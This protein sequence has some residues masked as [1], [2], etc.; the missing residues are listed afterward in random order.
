MN[1]FT[2]GFY[3]LAARINKVSGTQEELENEQGIVS[4]KLPELDLAMPDDDL[5]KLTGE[6][7]RKWNESDV[8][9]EW[10]K[11]GEENERYWKGDQFTRPDVGKNRPLIDNA[12]FEAVETY[13]PQIKRQ[14]PEPVVT[15]KGDP[16]KTTPDQDAFIRDLQTELAEIADE[17]KMRLKL[18]A[19]TRHWITY[20]V[21]VEKVGWDLNRDIPT[22]KTIRPQKIILD[23]DAATDEDGYTGEY[24]GEYRKVAAGRLIKIIGDG[25]KSAM[26]VKL[27]K[28]L[29]KDDLGTKIQFIEWWTPQYMCWT[30]KDKVLLKKKN[31]HWNYDKTIPP[32]PVAPQIEGQPPVAP[33]QAQ[34]IK[35]VNHF[36]APKIPYIL[37]SVYNLGEKPVDDTS[38]IGQNLSNQDTINKR[39]RQIDRNADN[40]N[41]GLVISLERSGLTTSQA[42]GVSDA[43]RKGGVVAIPTG[44]PSDAIYRPQLPALPAEVFADLNDHRN[45]LGQIFGTQG[46]SPQGIKREDTVGGKIIVRGLDTDRIGGGVTQ[47]VEQIADDAFNWFVQLLYVYSELWQQRIQNAPKVKVSVKEGSLIPKDSVSLANQAISLGNAGKMSLVDMYKALDYANPEEMAANVWLE[48]NAPQLL[49]KDNP[50]VQEAIKMQQQA[51]AAAQQAKAQSEQAKSIPLPSESMSFKDMPPDGKVQMAAKVGIILHPEGIAAHDDYKDGRKNDAAASM[52]AARSATKPQ[53]V[54]ATQ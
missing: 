49:Y 51:A 3:S 20:L 17:I 11:A 53:N 43:L 37:L 38:L 42:K 19:V 12:I 34:T 25:E 50:L 30:L 39:E 41:N 13:L 15:M 22:M 4:E 6:W 36:A 21:G 48:A 52:A 16:R 44:S 2:D 26:A 10:E 24:V 46:L 40:A 7:E 35:G 27:I 5:T 31:P 14:D 1:V 33:P 29:V 9:S 54:I 32:A 23:P 45:R 18:G 28:D 47:Y 8:K